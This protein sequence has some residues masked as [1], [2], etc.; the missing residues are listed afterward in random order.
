MDVDSDFSP[1]IR[2]L[3]VEYCK[4]LYGV[5]SVANIVT[6]GVM[7]PKGAVRNCARIIGIERDKRDYYLALADK[8][9]K[10]IPTKVGTS[11][12]SCEADLR[13][14]FAP[15]DSDDEEKSQYKKDANEI[16]DY[17]KLV[18]GVLSTME[19]MQQA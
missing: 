3:V 7:A 15:D 6:K 11:F 14:A 9:A 16:L 12:E 4:K 13:L 1:D 18:E 2:D 5:Q 17:A 10:M 19:C 8:I